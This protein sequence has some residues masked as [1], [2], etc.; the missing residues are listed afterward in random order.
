M[1]LQQEQEIVSVGRDGQS[2]S[3]SLDVLVLDQNISQY[4]LL[5]SSLTYLERI[6]DERGLGVGIKVWSVLLVS[7]SQIVVLTRL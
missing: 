2:C 5:G 1:A 4:P 7:T 3:L 6:V